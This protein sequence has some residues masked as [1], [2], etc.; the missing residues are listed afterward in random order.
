VRDS[1]DIIS[2]GK[3]RKNRTYFYI[4]RTASLFPRTKTKKDADQLSYPLR[5]KE[6]GKQC[7]F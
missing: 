6:H 5:V 7:E 3:N 4:N 2:M 1:N